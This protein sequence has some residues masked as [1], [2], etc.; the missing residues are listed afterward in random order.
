[1]NDGSTQ[2]PKLK[3]NRS[4][5]IDDS[6]DSRI[7]KNR[8]LE[9]ASNEITYKEQPKQIDYFKADNLGPFGVWIKK[10][11][12]DN[13]ELSAFKV[14]SIIFKKYRQVIDIKNRGK[15]KTEILFKT[16]D[17]ANR[18]LKDQTLSSHNLEAFIPGFRK[19]RKGLIKDVPLDISEDVIKEA[20]VS[21]V[22]VLEVKR[23]TRRNKNPTGDHDKRLKT[24]TILITFS[25]Q[26]LPKEI[27]LFYV[28][29]NVD[30]YVQR[31][32][33]CFKCLK[34]GHIAKTC[35]SKEHCIMCGLEEHKDNDGKCPRET[36]SCRN[37]NGSHKSID[38]S[39]P[40]YQK[41]LRVNVLMAYDNI[42]YVD[43]KKIIFSDSQ[44]PPKTKEHFPGINQQGTR[45]VNHVRTYY[46]DLYKIQKNTKYVDEAAH[47]GADEYTQLSTQSQEGPY[48]QIDP[49]SQY[50]QDY[51]V[52]SQQHNASTKMDLIDVTN[53]NGN[54][55]SS[56]EGNERIIV[57][58]LPAISRVSPQT[59][60]LSSIEL[61]P[62][63]SL[64]SSK[65]TKSPKSQPSSLQDTIKKLSSRANGTN[66]ENITVKTYEKA[67]KG[68]SKAFRLLN[69]Q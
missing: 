40:I 32:M 22:E 26:I 28:K 23:Q 37:C 63:D 18:I 34:F 49:I 42:F 56:P 46:S 25:G 58:N 66:K 9:V 68:T 16:R 1:M 14:G 43:A 36:P 4:R 57:T 65:S 54:S 52:S 13:Q 35:R 41:H 30:P 39:C 8:A 11:K 17:E 7:N 67:K 53:I 3:R 44:A 2:A 10:I 15:F 64:R 61:R 59:P 51:N 6:D 27:S 50:E 55:T 24:R 69:T 21:P 12:D 48:S 19:T 5:S 45:P 33:Q 47:I 31:P 62:P 60:Q 38:S 20:I 29:S